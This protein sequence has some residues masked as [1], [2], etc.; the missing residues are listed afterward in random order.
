MNP[1]SLD[2]IF[3]TVKIGKPRTASI[4]TTIAQNKKNF[5]QTTV[6]YEDN[7]K[8]S[9]SCQQKLANPEDIIISK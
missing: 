5:A 9:V 8:G 4:E 2:G 6:F 7:A 3:N 1:Y